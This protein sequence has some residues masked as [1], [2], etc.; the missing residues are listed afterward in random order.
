MTIRLTAIIIA[1]LDAIGWS[2]AAFNLLVT[3][4]DPATQSLDK[5][6]GYSITVLFVL[7]GLP[8]LALAI[9]DRAPRAALA[10]ALAFPVA[11]LVL[12]VV[13]AGVLP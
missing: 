6:G 12:L 9:T 7:T 3:D 11:F 4:G 8:A 10:F 1:V 5:L 2:L 13:A